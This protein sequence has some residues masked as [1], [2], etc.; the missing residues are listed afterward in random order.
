MDDSKMERWGA[1]GG[2]LFV[3]LTA[4]GALLPGSPPKTSDTA[5]KIVKFFNDHPNAIKWSAYVSLLGL[6]GLFWF[7]GSVWRVM[8]RGEGGTPLLTVSAFAGALLASALASVGAI[9]L[10]VVPIVG[11]RNIGSQHV[12]L[13]YI[14]SSNIAVGT[15]VGI[16]VF[17]LFFSLVIVRSRVLPAVMGWLGLVIAAIAVVGGAIVSTTSDGIFYVSFV[18]FLAFL[19]WTLVVSILMLRGPSATPAPNTAEMSAA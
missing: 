16:V 4:V 9:V 13:F 17:V 8:R 11:V 19:L 15:E 14:M 2:I 5:A 12:R 1:F 10:A 7:L 18:G 6:I 3:V